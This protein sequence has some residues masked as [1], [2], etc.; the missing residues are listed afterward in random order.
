MNLTN[1]GLSAAFASQ[2]RIM[3]ASNNISNASTE[4][5]SR[6]EVQLA[7]A[8]ETGTSVGFFGR[9]VNVSTVQ[10]SYS[11]FLTTQ[12]QKAQSKG[13]GLDAYNQQVSQLNNLVADRTV[14]LAP[15]MQ[16]FFDG[17]QAVA[18]TPSD[19]AARQEMLSRADSLVGQFNDINDFMNS[20]R[21]DINTQIRNSVANINSH[22]QRIADLNKQIKLQQAANG[23]QPP[24]DLLDQRDLEVSTLNRVVTVNVSIQD[25]DYAVTVGNGQVLVSGNSA[26]TMTAKPSAADPRDYT[27]L[28]ATPAGNGKTINMPINEDRIGGGS[29][30]GLFRYRNTTLGTIQR[31]L[32]Q[33]A[34]GIGLAVNAIQAQG[35][36]LNGVSGSPIFS[37]GT[38]DVIDNGNNRGVGSVSV[39]IDPSG[40][41][42][43]KP[44]DYTVKYDGINYTVTRHFD[45]TDV[46]TGSTLSNVSIDGMIVSAGAGAVTGDSWSIKPARDA[47]S[48]LSIVMAAPAGVAAASASGGPTNGDNA[49][50]MAKLQT[51][52]ILD[53][54]TTSFTDN[55]SALVNTVGVAAQQNDAENKAQQT[56]INQTYNAQQS[57][58]GV[59]LNEEY[60]NLTRYQEQF[61]AASK[62]LDITAN[63]FN[64]IIGIKTN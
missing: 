24:N 10:R 60:V 41:S 58:S 57:V 22:V 3:T 21:E 4:G 63:I 20:Q 36:D 48:K 17:I 18:S 2:A 28:A 12:L 44:S 29:L 51:K 26:F 19:P 25:G 47:A 1:I 53:G 64:I 50:L 32:G 23:G 62:I 11:Q 40:A 16:S 38:P 43:I 46:Y 35:I 45:N 61:Q 39:T 59:N 9:G 34:M 6:Q 42:A 30:G 8:G 14:G 55:Y 56:L 33:T 7:S 15:A 31:Q 13:A 37:V 52:K 27:V 5:Y 49:L 54:A